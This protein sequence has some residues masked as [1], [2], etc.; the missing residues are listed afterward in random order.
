M[1]CLISTGRRGRVKPLKAGVLGIV[2]AATVVLAAVAAPRALAGW[3]APVPISSAGVIRNAQFAAD[4]GGDAIAVWSRLTSSENPTSGIRIYAIEAAFRPAAGAWQP[5]AI[6]G[7]AAVQCDRGGCEHVPGIVVAIGSRGQ[8]VVAWGST[9]SGTGVIESAWRSA[10]GS[11]RPPTV[12]TR[13]VVVQIAF[14]QR[15]NA[16]ASELAGGRTANRALV[17]FKPAGR[18]WRR[19]VTV[20]A[21]N[22]FGPQLAIDAHGDATVV[23]S[24]TVSLRRGQLVQ[25]A[26]RPAGGH[27]RPPVTLGRADLT[28][29]P[30]LAVDPRGDAIVSWAGRIRLDR[31]CTYSVQAAFK[32]AVGRWRRAV[33]LARTGVG[34]DLQ[35]AFDRAGK[36]TAVW[37]STGSDPSVPPA[38]WSASRPA[39]GSWH[40]PVTIATFTYGVSALQLTL[41]PQ[42]DALAAWWVT[43]TPPDPSYLQVVMASSHGPW[44][45]PMSLGGERVSGTYSLPAIGAALDSQG[46]AVMVWVQDLSRDQQIVD[47]A[48]FTRAG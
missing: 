23:W 2:V 36:A 9:V 5:A 41:D 31:C 15:G 44:Q 47:A 34:G 12:F 32:P 18:A 14:D 16:F 42:G 26:V 1:A 46:N 3:T 38:V 21:A 13:N 17:A 24:K 4:A 45:P 10:A 39:G 19:P 11:W 40:A 28:V 33:T 30:Y 20:G 22:G 8:A 27:W 25:A 37:S 35:V 6:I 48:T 29:G 43:T 7:T